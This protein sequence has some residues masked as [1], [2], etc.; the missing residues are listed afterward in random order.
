MFY[1]ARLRQ[2]L[3]D[4]VRKLGATVDWEGFELLFWRR[5]ED[6]TGKIARALED[7][8]MEHAN[9]IAEVTRAHIL[10]FRQSQA[11]VWERD[12]FKQEK[13]VADGT[14]TLQAEETKKARGCQDR[15][16]QDRELSRTA[17]R[18]Q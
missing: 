7:N 8:F 15:R 10:V 17:L 2:S 4:L 1:S 18:S 5:L 14:R 12:L 13:R 11:T 16:R 3:N 9:P 6:G